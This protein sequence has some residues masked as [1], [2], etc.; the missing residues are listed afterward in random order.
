[1]NLHSDENDLIRLIAD[2][3]QR[4]F[5][6]IFE[7]YYGVLGEFVYK[8]TGSL[9]KSQ[10]I[11]QDVF[12]KLWQNRTGLTEVRNMK[13]YIFILCR[14]HTYNELRKVAVEKKVLVFM[15]HQE[16]QGNHVED[17]T[18]NI[19]VYRQLIDQAV[20]KL[21]KQAQKVYLMSR[22]ERLKYEEIAVTLGISSETVKKHLQ[23][24]K[25][26]IAS[27]VHTQING[28]ILMVLLTPLMIS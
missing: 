1:M 10:E 2:G 14:N 13:S 9:E 19:E 16:L 3:D 18:D 12:V 26:F 23:Y 21:P 20:D 24:A 28:A 6:V 8:V 27:D 5:S 7:R 15:D 4:A 11:V 22:D 25:K 17:K